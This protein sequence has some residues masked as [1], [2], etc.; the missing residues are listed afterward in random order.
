MLVARNKIFHSRNWSSCRQLVAYSTQPVAE[1]C[2]FQ[3]ENPKNEPPTKKI[4]FIDSPEEY[5][6]A[7]PFSEVP[8]PGSFNMIW[9]MLAP[10][11]KYRG[12]GLK[13]LQQRISSEYGK[14]VKFPGM[15]GRDP[16]IMLY[17]ADEVEKVFR[18]EGQWPD[19]KSFDF[20]D[21]FRSK[22][23]PELFQGHGG[24]LQEWVDFRWVAIDFETINLFQAGPA[25]AGY[26]NESQ[27][28][29][30]A[31]ENC[32]PVHCGGGNNHRRFY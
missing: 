18:N 3:G 27:S 32:V 31:T 24:L 9:N 16:I 10:G 28:R 23:R 14:V 5:Q 25:V 12:C 8:G 15:F 17:N 2:P 19:R 6:R 26:K 20:F 1:K 21:E 7:K 11:G 22:I 29:Y 13:Q 30:D 4:S